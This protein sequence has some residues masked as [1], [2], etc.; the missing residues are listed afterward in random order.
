MSMK[1]ADALVFLRQYGDDLSN[2]PDN[3]QAIS[4]VKDLLALGAKKVEVALYGDDD[5]ELS[6]DSELFLH[7][8]EQIS[9]D[10]L[11]LI[12]SIRPDE[13]SEEMPGVIRLWWD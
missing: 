2:G 6:F 3:E 9:L 11:Q 13:I 1:Y 5:D 10:M 4:F 7:L 8:P 12:V